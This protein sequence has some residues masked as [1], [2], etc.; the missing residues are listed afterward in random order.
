MGILVAQTD[1]IR[2]LRLF[3]LPLEGVNYQSAA[4]SSASLFSLAAEQHHFTLHEQTSIASARFFKMIFSWFHGL[5][6]DLLLILALTVMRENSR[7]IVIVFISFA[8]S[9]CVFT[10]FKFLS[11]GYN[12][13]VPLRFLCGL[14]MNTSIKMQFITSTMIIKC[15]I[16]M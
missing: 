2:C 6:P 9:P 13:S 7:F 12:Y 1:E 16:T 8:L 10:F 3:T 14:P 4:S 15:F 11:P 5:L